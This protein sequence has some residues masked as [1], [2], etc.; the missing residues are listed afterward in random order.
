[1][2]G[3]GIDTGGTCTDA[4]VYDL[5]ANRVLAAAKTETTKKDLKIGIEKALR[6]LPTDKL[7][8]CGQ[9]AL[10]TTL[11]TNACVED[12]GGRGKLIL[13][14]VSR[15]VLEE[16][17]KNYGFDNLADVM[18][19]ECKISANVTHS[20]QP[21]WAA[22]E[23]EVPAFI[24]HCDCVSIVQLFSADHLGAY[25][26]RAAEI[27]HRVSGVPV[28]LGNT[29]FPDRNAIRRGAG[30]LLNARLVPVIYAFLTAIEAVFG[31]MGMEHPLTIV[32]S[33]GSQM[34]K[35][36]ALRHPVETLLCGPAASVIGANTLARTEDAIV[37][38]MGGTT[39]DIAVIEG[40]QALR[41]DEGIQ[42]GEWKTFVKGLY[43]DTFGLG[44]DTAVHYDFDGKVYLENY[45]V[46]PLCALAKVYPQIKENLERLDLSNRVHP[47]YLH[48]FFCLIGDP[49]G[50]AALSADERKLCAALQKRPLS[51]EEIGAVMNEEIYKL[52]L[53][54]LEKS[55]MIMRSGFTPTD[56]MHILGDYDAYD[57]EASRHAAA[58][59]ARSAHEDGI[60][61]LCRT[62]YD[63]VE[64]RMYCNVVRIL[65]ESSWSGPNHEVP[66]EQMRRYIA[67]SYEMKKRGRAGLL[68]SLFTTRAKL[69]GVGAPTHV[70][71][72]KVAEL[73]DTEAVIPEYAQVANAVGAIAGQVVARS[74]VIIKPIPESEIFEVRA[75][76]AR[77]P[78]ETYEEALA[79]AEE[80]GRRLAKEKA[81]AQGALGK[82][83]VAAALTRK[84][85]KTQYGR[86]IWFYSQLICT[87]VGKSRR[88]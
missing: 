74:E 72:P 84:E 33:D 58:F 54:H 88:E 16:T 25:E 34:S 75:E 6:A 38:D 44:G 3:I 12:R 13:I 52:S 14:G 39:T 51:L 31:E 2:I 55:G 37:V 19:L 87:A 64:K 67:D 66:G 8:A 60:E 11:A 23:R 17:Y 32:R 70:F 26:T 71:L 27:I 77:K 69:I 53:E 73:L 57:G 24:A 43:I 22:F 83:E 21:D 41:T 86:N 81:R 5:G 18:L 40:G 49:E 29:L 47:Y 59:I 42:V 46:V 50:D 10:S 4:V 85:A 9:V 48:E 63:L 1:M 7:R 30:A 15:R 78:F 68:G 76:D 20:E 61:S 80:N 56:A 36:F 35:D 45:R 65:L 62:V 79:F 28:I 82:I